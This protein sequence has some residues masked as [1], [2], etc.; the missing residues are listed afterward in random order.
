MWHTRTTTGAMARRVSEYEL[1][2]DFF[3]STTV[4]LAVDAATYAEALIGS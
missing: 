1:V 4:V 2:R 3:A